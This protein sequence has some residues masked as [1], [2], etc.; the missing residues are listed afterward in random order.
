MHAKELS[1]PALEHKLTRLARNA[2][3]LHVPLPAAD[4]VDRFAKAEQREKEERSRERHTESLTGVVA[5][6]GDH[7]RKRILVHLERHW[8]VAKW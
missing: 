8:G 6:E 3:G 7:H 5:M 4:Q 1:V 2:D